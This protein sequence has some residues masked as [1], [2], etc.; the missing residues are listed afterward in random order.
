MEGPVETFLYTSISYADLETLKKLLTCSIRGMFYD[1]G[2][3]HFRQLYRSSF[4]I[5]FKVGEDF[6][7]P[8]R[9]PSRPVKKFLQTSI[10]RLKLRIYESP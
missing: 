10:Y 5:E 8:S 2:L 4:F 1:L 6:Y 9:L 7:K 3:D